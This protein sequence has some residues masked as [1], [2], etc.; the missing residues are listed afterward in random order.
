MGIV[1]NRSRSVAQRAPAPGYNQAPVNGGWPRSA[2]FAPLAQLS[3]ALPAGT[4]SAAT[5]DP[6]PT[7]TVPIFL[8]ISDV[9]AILRGRSNYGAIRLTA[10]GDTADF[11]IG[12][13]NFDEECQLLGNVDAA[14]VVP[15]IL[16]AAPA[17]SPVDLNAGQILKGTTTTGA[18]IVAGYAAGVVLT[19]RSLVDEAAADALCAVLVK[20]VANSK[21]LAGNP[22]S[23]GLSAYDG[24][25]TAGSF[26]DR[27]SV[28]L[29]ESDYTQAIRNGLSGTQG[30]NTFV[31]G[32][33]VVCDVVGLWAAA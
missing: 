5:F 17:P 9:P 15:N 33:G 2:F 7:I 13:A 20:C 29:R 19:D 3:G 21:V 28:I 12:F 32:N 10:G 18:V 1:S 11:P 30:P 26:G 16:R 14:P 25:G 6:H 31:D 4:L 22:S 24:A 27:T 8:F 23:G